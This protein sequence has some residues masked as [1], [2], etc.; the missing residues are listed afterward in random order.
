[1]ERPL[2]P[3]RGG[4]AGGGRPDVDRRPRRFHPR[5]VVRDIGAELSSG[6][7]DLRSLCG[8]GQH[9]NLARTS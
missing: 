6:V 3:C 4:V 1:M 5:G 2:R 7:G 8:V 9:Q